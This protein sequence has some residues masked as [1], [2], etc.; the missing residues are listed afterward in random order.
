MFERLKKNIVGNIT[1]PMTNWLYNR[2]NVNK[3]Y[4]KMIKSEYYSQE[5]L[6]NIQFEK[7]KKILTYANQFVPF[8][9]KRFKEVGFEVNDLKTFD[10]LKK[11]PCLTR[12]DVI[13]NHNDM[14][15]I[16]LINFIKAAENSSRGPAEPILFARFK[17]DRLIRN[18]SSGS[19]GYPTTFYEDG[20]VTG[21]NWAEELRFKKWYGINPGEKEARLVRFSTDYM[22]CDKKI[23]FRKILWNQLLLPGVNLQEKDYDYICKQL[24]E[25]KPKVLWGFTSALTGVANYIL[26]TN[27]YKNLIK[28]ELIIT[29]AAPLY[30]HERQ[31]LNDVFNCSV[32]NIYG[33]RELGH[34]AALCSNGRFHINQENYF[35]ENE[36]IDSLS[37]ELLVTSLVKSPMPFI[38]YRTGDLGI[39]KSYDCKCGKSL[40][41]ID[42]FLGRTG[43][44]FITS[45]GKMISPNFWCRTFMEK[46][47]ARSIQ[48]FQV[49][50]K[51]DKSIKI[52][53]VKNSNFTTE[54]E[55]DLK[56]YLI[57]NFS[58]EVPFT[59][60]YV[61]E[62]KPQIS[63]KY[64]MVVKE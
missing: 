26:S 33:T 24:V 5:R 21:M 55:S 61:S 47:R 38:R 56:K 16:R 39:V 31:I 45:N 52:L 20:S 37:S 35:V 1:F 60:E 51:K 32:T 46:S 15:D 28:P 41:I 3:N 2:R 17:K 44:V 43:E 14:V 49:I 13:D 8:Y 9:Q 18:T 29:W 11:I 23:R 36:K 62:I 12:Q 34:I 4:K 53:L 63:G 40:Q 64:Q 30:D 58:E 10:D 54:I 22:P 59:F 57:T 48:R 6:Q 42:E 50:Y 7:L 19:T 27:S 25:F